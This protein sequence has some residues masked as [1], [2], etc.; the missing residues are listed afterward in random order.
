TELIAKWLLASVERLIEGIY[1]EDLKDER[2]FEAI[3]LEK[4]TEII[5]RKLFEESE[6]AIKEHRREPQRI[7]HNS[8]KNNKIQNDF[9]EKESKTFLYRSKRC[10]QLAKLFNIRRSFQESG[11]TCSKQSNLQNIFQ[12]NKMKSAIQQLVRM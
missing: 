10:K 4:P 8:Q 5:I 11:F 3:D 1:I 7:R 6:R 12:S 9:W 2:F